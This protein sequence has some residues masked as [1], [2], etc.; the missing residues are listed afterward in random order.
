MITTDSVRWAGVEISF[1]FPRWRLSFEMVGQNLFRYNN[2][3]ECSF[4]L[5][6]CFVFSKKR[7]NARS[8]ASNIMLRS[9][10]W[11]R[12]RQWLHPS[13]YYSKPLSPFTSVFK[14][15]AAFE[16]YSP[17]SDACQWKESAAEFHSKIWQLKYPWHPGKYA[18][19]A[20]HNLKTMLNC[21]DTLFHSANIRLTKHLILYQNL[22]S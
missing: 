14:F 1:N 8:W 2:V 3:V 6:W 18:H 13:L 10:K 17:T 5:V 7:R 12:K 9:L 20:Q 15:I 16:Y 19:L 11:S 21:Q 22:N 4:L